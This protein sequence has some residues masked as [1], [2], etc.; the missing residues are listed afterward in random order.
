MAQTK[1]KAGK[2]GSSSKFN[3]ADIKSSKDIQGLLDYVEEDEII[4][5]DNMIL[6]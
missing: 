2:K 4:H 1:T 5:R 3:L 6:L